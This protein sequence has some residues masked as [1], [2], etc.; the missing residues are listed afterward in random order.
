MMKIMKLML[1][2]K[3]PITKTKKVT[4]VMRMTVKKLKKILNRRQKMKKIPKTEKF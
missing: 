1:L 2:K 4:M 3:K